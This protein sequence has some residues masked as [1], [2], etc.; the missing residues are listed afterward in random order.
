MNKHVF[1]SS[2]FKDLVTF[3]EKV[4][5]S[6]RQLGAVDISMEHFG[7]RD[8]RPK[9][10]CIRLIED[11]TDVFVGIYAFRYGYIPEEDAI[12]IT[13]T[14]YHAAAA[15]G[16]PRHIYLVDESLQ[17]NWNPAWIDQGTSAQQLAAFKAGLQKNR[18]VEFFSNPDQL[19][20]SVAAVLGRHFSTSPPTNQELTLRLPR[21]QE[22]EI[23]GRKED[24]QKIK[25]RL[26]NQ[27]S[28]VLVNGLGGIGKTTLAQVYVDKFYRKYRHIAW[29][30]ELT[31]TFESNLV[32]A[33]GLLPSLE[34]KPEGKELK[35]LFAEVVMKLKEKP[36][37]NLL[38]IDN[39]NET[40]SSY[41][42]I[43]PKPPSW[44]VLVTSR[45][46]IERFETMELGFLSES[47]ALAL[48]QKH[49]QRE[50]LSEAEIAALVKL[51]DYHT[52]TIEILAK[53]AQKQRTDLQKLSSAIESDL[54]ANVYVPHQGAK[55]D[56]ITSYLCS[57][58]QLTELNED[59]HWL[60]KQLACLPPEFHAYDQLVDLI[61]PAQSEKE[62]IFS[63]TL[64]ELRDKGWVLYNEITDQYKMHRI[65]AAVVVRQIPPI[66]EEVS[67]LIN[68]VIDHLN[69]DQSKDNPVDKFQ[70]VPYG[71]ILNQLFGP[72]EYP[73]QS[74]LQNNLAL[75]HRALG[76]YDQAKSLLER[77]LALAEKNFGPDH[78]NTATRASNLA[79]VHRALG[80]YDQAKSLLERALA[81]FENHLGPEHPH[82]RTVK[83][84]L[85][86]LL[87]E[88]NE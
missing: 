56:R 39:A 41:Y 85:E 53:T 54:R 32:N 34:I 35:D 20:A 22:R 58:F 70:W 38:V 61:D 30:D 78:P 13:E 60:L 31:D 66:P 57:I 5:G 12:S 47:E 55:I 73:A 65:T 81:A 77:A 72:N 46:N 75:V 59:E 11:E 68:Q 6:I 4:R 43:L 69:I 50:Q 83:S 48:F 87:K 44:H 45:E 29:V 80:E 9:E 18:M 79:T 71:Q 14:E 16:I 1:V 40:L 26:F 27:Q 52:L 63:E 74:T 21:T 64:E 28:V 62:D 8:A 76:E 10:E 42:D 33:T 88:M 86:V 2:T 51:V 24:L 23:V 82:T 17:A 67:P 37:P 7:A 84:N 25:Q 19:A 3:R 36:G 15:A 49:Y